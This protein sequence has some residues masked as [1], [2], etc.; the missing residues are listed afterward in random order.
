[1]ASEANA[2]PK[3]SQNATAEG[4]F[5]R[6]AFAAR[7]QMSHNSKL[8]AGSEEVRE[9]N[10][11]TA[12]KTSQQPQVPIRSKPPHLPPRQRTSLSSIKDFVP[13]T[14]APPKD[15]ETS[16]SW[17][18]ESAVSTALETSWQSTST[19]P[20]DITSRRTASI[21][22]VATGFSR[23]SYVA[24]KADTVFLDRVILGPMDL[25]SPNR[26]GSQLIL[27]VYPATGQLSIEWRQEKKVVVSI[28]FDALSAV[29]VSLPRVPKRER[30]AS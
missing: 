9:T 7:R 12:K 4:P 10:R 11:A 29:Q 22:S 24:G 25:A 30:F 6:A 17:T 26:K 27:K 20:S 1:M 23:D 3:T 16:E 13:A 18:S 2:R 19:I 21:K 28:G 5:A 8:P 15:I 14:I